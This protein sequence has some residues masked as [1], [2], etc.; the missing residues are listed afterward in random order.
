MS[1]D[2][3]RAA[4]CEPSLE[5]GTLRSERAELRQLSGEVT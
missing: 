4:H 5:M 3:Q 1:Q 2:V